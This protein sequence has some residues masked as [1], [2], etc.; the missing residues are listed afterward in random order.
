VYDIAGMNIIYHD[1][2]LI[3]LYYINQAAQFARKF[4][5]LKVD[6]DAVF[7][8]EEAEEQEVQAVVGDNQIPSPLFLISRV[9][10][11]KN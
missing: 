10:K 6:M 5:L 2:V 11:L 9:A 7:E 8:F 4:Y 3:Y 1:G